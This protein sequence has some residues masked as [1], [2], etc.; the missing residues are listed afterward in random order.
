MR[1]RFKKVPAR[2]T[3][4]IS[5]DKS[6]L[7]IVRIWEGGGRG[8]EVGWVWRHLREKDWKR[9][10]RGVCTEDSISSLLMVSEEAQAFPGFIH[11]KGLF[12]W[13]EIDTM[14]VVYGQS[15]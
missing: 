4:E 12:G 6:D 14:C 10:R 9:R 5:R 13:Y 7:R 8:V 1:N 3:A 11:F 2:S 15:N